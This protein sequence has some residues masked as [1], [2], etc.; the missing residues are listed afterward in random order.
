MSPAA[1]PVIAALENET[2]GPNVPRGSVNEVEE[3]AAVEP[4]VTVIEPVPAPD[5]TLSV[6]CVPP[7]AV[8]CGCG[9]PPK[10]TVGE[11]PKPNPLIVT[12]VPG[13]PALG[14]NVEIEG[15][16][17]N[18][19][20]DGAVPPGVVTEIV[21]VLAPAGT[22]VAI[23]VP[24]ASTVNVGWL[25]VLNVT[26][27]APVKLVPVRTTDVPTTPDEGLKPV[28]VGADEPP[29]PVTVNEVEDGTVPC[30]VVTEMVAV[31]APAG[32]VVPI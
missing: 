10:V 2:G 19:L 7:T 29:P 26:A 11:L 28:S 9:I 21:P 15:E 1:I 30:G 14:E 18:G 22:V 31:E 3:T 16:T 5:G 23:C 4:T 20:A 25:V 24:P 8:R 32:T 6:I 12:A 27:V 13:P 17:V